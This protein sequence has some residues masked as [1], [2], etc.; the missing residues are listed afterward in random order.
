MG[1]WREKTNYVSYL[2]LISPFHQATKEAEME[3]GGSL[4][5]SLNCNVPTGVNAQRCHDSSQVK[6]FWDLTQ[7][8]V[9]TQQ[10]RMGPYYFVS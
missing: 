1:T 4:N 3:K 2:F 7:D 10:T 9:N 5:A 8:P 6:T